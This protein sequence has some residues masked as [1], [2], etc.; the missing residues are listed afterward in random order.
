MTRWPDHPI[1]LFLNLFVDKRAGAGL[2]W[3]ICGSPAAARLET[4]SARSAW[5]D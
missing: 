2:F 1:S 3:N 4:P 5:I